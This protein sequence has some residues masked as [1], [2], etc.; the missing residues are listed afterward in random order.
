MVLAEIAPPKKITPPVFL[1]RQPAQRQREL[2]SPVWRRLRRERAA[3]AGSAGAG[4]SAAS[5][6]A[7]SAGGTTSATDAASPSAAGFSTAGFFSGFGGLGAGFFAVSIR[8][9]ANS[10]TCALMNQPVQ[11]HDDRRL[12][13]RGFGRGGFG[14]L[15]RLG[16][17]RCGSTFAFGHRRGRDGN[18]RRRRFRDFGRRRERLDQFPPRAFR[19]SR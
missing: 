5:S 4:I 17:C 18:F 9:S 1:I 7:T 14:G 2:Q 10:K 19:R 13:R 3:A 12:F 15:R 6:A 11:I 16:R 8:P